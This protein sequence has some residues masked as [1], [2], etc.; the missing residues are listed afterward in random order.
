MFLIVKAFV[1]A[2]HSL[3]LQ[4][5]SSKK[6]ISIFDMYIPC[7]ASSQIRARTHD[8]LVIGLFELLGNPTT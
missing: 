8:V 6:K 1:T 7:E 4:Y 5:S 3:I 2:Y